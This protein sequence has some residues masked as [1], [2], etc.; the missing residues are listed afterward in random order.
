MDLYPLFADLKGRAVL[1]IGGGAVAERK[2]ALLLRAGA[3]I[4][5][6]ATR[7]SDGLLALKRQGEL[8]H[9]ALVFTPAQLDGVWL[10]VAATD[11]RELNQRVAAAAAARRIW[12]NVV[13]DVALSSFQVPAI[14]DRSP[15]VI[16]VSSGGSAPMLARRV[17][18]RIE[19]LLAPSLG[20]LAG[21]LDRWRARIRAARPQVDARRDWYDA[22]LEGGVPALVEAGQ[23]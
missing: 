9:R 13:D 16:A 5:V 7:L 1:V 15:L 23:V 20:T 14:V 8:A 6:V 3:R 4:E 17:R 19:R 2:I 21:L 18:E 10:A 12:V 11:D 22:L